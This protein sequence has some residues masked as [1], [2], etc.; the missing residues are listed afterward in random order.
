MG[1]LIQYA[2]WCNQINCTSSTLSTSSPRHPLFIFKPD[3]D[4]RHLA[5]VIQDVVRD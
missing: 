4:L 3:S 1:L 5:D 2:F